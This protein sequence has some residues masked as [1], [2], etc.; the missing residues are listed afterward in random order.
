[1]ISKHAAFRA[2]AGGRHQNLLKR[3]VLHRPI[4]ARH[5]YAHNEKSVRF[6]EISVFTDKS[7]NSLESMRVVIL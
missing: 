2:L 1:M 4:L 5:P 6:T 7:V 3:V